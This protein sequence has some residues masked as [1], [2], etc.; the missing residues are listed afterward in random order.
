[1]G[2]FC[3]FGMDCDLEFIFIFEILYSGHDFL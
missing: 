1:M 3:N 2:N